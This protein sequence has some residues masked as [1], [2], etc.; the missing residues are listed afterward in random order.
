MCA[1]HAFHMPSPLPRST[2][3]EV[4]LHWA[5]HEPAVAHAL[6]RSLTRLGLPGY[7]AKTDRQEEQVPSPFA[8]TYALRLP[9]TLRD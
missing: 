8:G 3:G 5:A 2:T 4:I 9:C 6:L 7:F 1:A